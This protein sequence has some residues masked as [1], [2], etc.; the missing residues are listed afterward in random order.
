MERGGGKQRTKGHTQRP[1]KLCEL[2]P[3]KGVG[4][5][6]QLGSQA[7][8]FGDDPQASSPS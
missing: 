5:T 1:A 3:G 2:L 6:F 8:Y 7:T 4:M